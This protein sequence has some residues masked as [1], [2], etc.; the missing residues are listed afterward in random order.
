VKGRCSRS[1]GEKKH[2]YGNHSNT[3]KAQMV[4]YIAC[5]SGKTGLWKMF[6]QQKQEVSLNS[7]DTFEWH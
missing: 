5:N 6:H 2:Y 4:A 3:F 7:G 1:G